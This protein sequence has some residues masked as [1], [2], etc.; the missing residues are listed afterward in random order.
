MHHLDLTLREEG[1]E[2]D[3]FNPREAFGS[4]SDS[5]HVYNTPRAWYM[6]RC[7]NPSDCWDG[8]EAVFTPESDD[9]LE[10]DSGA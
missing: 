7:L 9:P 2:E 3:I 10:P 1:E 8:D 6:Q 5:D 4:H